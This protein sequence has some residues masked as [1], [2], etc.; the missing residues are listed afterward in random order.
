ML[1]LI[2]NEGG[3][4]LSVLTIAL[5]SVVGSMTY[6][7]SKQVPERQIY[8]FGGKLSLHVPASWAVTQS[9]DKLTLEKPSAE[10]FP[11]TIYIERQI[12][13]GGDTQENLQQIV[14]GVTQEQAES[15]MGYR[16]LSEGDSKL[17][18]HP[19]K[20]VE[21]SVVCDAPDT[22]PEDGVLPTILVGSAIAVQSKTE[23]YKIS[24]RA[25]AE[26]FLSSTSEIQSILKSLQIKSP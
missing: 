8:A 14:H 19:S 24:A 26:E 18:G 4:D 22:L 7:G 1:H 10:D 5:I 16:V 15:C 12:P 13:L 3:L 2:R 11:D 9:K 25:E 23:I 21:F 17:S 20:Q 6:I